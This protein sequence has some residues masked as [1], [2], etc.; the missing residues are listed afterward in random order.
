MCVG[1]ARASAPDQPR[2]SLG[3]P[4]R[5]GCLRATRWRSGSS[6][7]WARIPRYLIGRV[8]GIEKWGR[9]LVSPTKSID[10]TAP[11]GRPALG[12]PQPVPRSSTVPR[13]PIPAPGEGQR[14]PLAALDLR[15]SYR[16]ASGARPAALGA[17]QGFA[18]SL[19][20]RVSADV[21][22]K[23]QSMVVVV[24]CLLVALQ[25]GQR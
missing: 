14:G 4:A 17:R 15:G 5:H 18:N 11:R 3:A 23:A 6:T 7:A 12:E 21:W 25:L 1:R 13:R 22:V 20:P 9:Q 24:Q 8:V 2:R 19:V 16:E 10:A